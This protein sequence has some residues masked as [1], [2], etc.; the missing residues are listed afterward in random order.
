MQLW[1]QHAGGWAMLPGPPGRLR[2]ARLG[3]NNREWAWCI[4]D[5]RLWFADLSAI[6]DA[7]PGSTQ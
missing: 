2:S 3:Y 1:L 6:W 7:L 4:T 5:D